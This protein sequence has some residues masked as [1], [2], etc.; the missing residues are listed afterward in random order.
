[1]IVLQTFR[2]C[3]ILLPSFDE[4][5]RSLSKLFRMHRKWSI[6]RWS[7][8]RGPSGLYGTTYYN[9]KCLIWYHVLLPEMPHMGAMYKANTGARRAHITTRNETSQNRPRPKI[10]NT[11]KRWVFLKLHHTVLLRYDP[12]G[13]KLWLLQLITVRLNNMITVD[14]SLDMWLYVFGLQILSWVKYN[15]AGRCTTQCEHA[16]VH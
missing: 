15:C 9:Q 4:L 8:Y 16:W 6:Y 7:A 12:S 1:M 3:S 5:V 2:K 10:I 13:I 14:N 11:G